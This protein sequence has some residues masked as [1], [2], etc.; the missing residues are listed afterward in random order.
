M[1]TLIET[2]TIGSGGASSIEFTSIPQD[3]I[4]L[5]VQVSGRAVDN[6][7]GIL[8]RFN[9]DTSNISIRYLRAA[10]GS[11]TGNS[12]DFVNGLVARSTYTA[13]TFGSTSI[14]IPNYTSA[15]TKPF[16][17]DAVAENVDANAHLLQIVAGHW[18]STSAISSVK[19]TADSGNLAEYST[20]SLYIIS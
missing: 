18:N 10:S 17:I 7:P 13:N 1:I 12:F 20:A 11:I 14:S 8:C 2:V 4:D 5:L 19:I 16:S 15:S 6:T 9:G 3:G